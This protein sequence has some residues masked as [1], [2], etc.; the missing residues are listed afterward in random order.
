[1]CPY[2]ATNIHTIGV[3][4]GNDLLVVVKVVQQGRED[5]PAG[6][7]LVVANEVA[8][9][10]LKRIENERLVSLRDFEVRESP[11]VREV[12]LCDNGLHAQAGK[13]GVHLD[14]DTL[15]GLDTDDQLVTGNV[16]EDARSDILKLD[17]DLSLLLVECL[18]CLQDERHTVP[19][20][21]L[22]VC[23]HRGECGAS[24][25]LGDC[26][27]LLVAGLRAIE[28]LAVLSDDDVLGLDRGHASQ[29][30][31]LLVTD[32]FGGERDGALHS[33]Q[34]EDLQ[35]V[36]LHDI[37]DDAKLV[38]VTTTAFCA[39]WLFKCNLLC[40]S[41]SLSTLRWV[42]Y[43]DVVDVVP[44]PG[45]AKELVTEPENQDVLDH[46]LTKVVVNTEELILCPVG[47]KR[48][49]KLARALKILT[50]GLLDLCTR[51]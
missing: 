37:A 43:L 8:V 47:R 34:G 1:M 2:F 18:S 24:R 20:L 42:S 30:T 49:L 21:V 46:F 51:N 14:V 6:V 50:E 3:L 31:D 41:F 38:E 40:V 23:N 26:V 32:V 16:L 17:A 22:D 35:Q 5:S 13:L 44:V 48:L 25:I 12:E 29:D 15:V 45:C 39:K 11:P 36:V 33:E 27:V 10:A 7:K 4:H 28:R 19:S 9:I